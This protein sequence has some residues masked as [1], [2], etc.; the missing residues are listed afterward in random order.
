MFFRMLCG[1]LGLSLCG[2]VLSQD[3]DSYLRE[4]AERNN[5]YQAANFRLIAAQKEAEAAGTLPDPMLTLGLSGTDVAQDGPQLQQ[6]NLMQELPLAGK[7]SLER[8][9]AGAMAT[10]ARHERDMV[11]V[12]MVARFKTQFADYF[13][14]GQA[15]VTT[16]EHLTLLRDLEQVV[17]TSYKNGKAHYSDLIGI[18][19]EIDTLAN[20]LQTQQAALEPQ[21]AALAILLGRPTNQALPLPDKLPLGTPPPPLD[22]EALSRLLIDRNPGLAAINERKVADRFELQRIAK[23]HIP[24]LQVGLEWMNPL[25]ANSLGG[26]DDLMIMV[27]ANLPLYR[28]RYQAQTVAAT[29]RLEAVGQASEHQLA[30]LR[31]A[32][33]QASF[34]RDD[35]ERKL[36]LYRDQVLPKAEESLKVISSAFQ[37][38]ERSYLDLVEAERA[39]LA[40]RLSLFEAMANGFKAQSMLEMLLGTNPLAIKEG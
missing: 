18:Q 33:R 36:A 5:A 29:A 21:S 13:F 12:E 37:N 30:E 8:K 16:Q 22:D 11:A 27:G 34:E 4:L 15:A 24:N 25:R 38:G 23:R 31:L 10:M 35:A 7:L 26:S 2:S 1:L 6:L 17:T 9:Q 19:V 32:Y 28:K 39:L 40:F 20:Q 3:L 14:A